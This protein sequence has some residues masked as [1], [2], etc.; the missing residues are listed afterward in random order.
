MSYY[1]FYM[2]VFIFIAYPIL[3]ILLPL[4][5]FLNYRK[6]RL[7]KKIIKT[8]NIVF[9]LW[10]LIVSLWL[11]SDEQEFGSY[12]QDEGDVVS[13]C[14]VSLVLILM[15]F[16]RIRTSVYSILSFSLIVFIAHLV[17]LKFFPN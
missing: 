4:F 6:E 13:Y 5:Y 3:G 8:A 14:S 10:I 1:L 12:F 11:I 15:L 9:G 16:K 2:D 17:S 7:L